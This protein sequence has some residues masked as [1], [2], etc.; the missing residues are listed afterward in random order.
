MLWDGGCILFLFYEYLILF[1]AQTSAIYV[2]SEC[3]QSGKQDAD[4]FV[5]GFTQCKC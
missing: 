4:D 5:Y 3:C 1:I 2:F